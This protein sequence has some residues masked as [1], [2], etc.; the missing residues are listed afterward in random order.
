MVGAVGAKSFMNEEFRGTQKAGGFAWS[1][2]NGT[3]SVHVIEFLRM[4]Q[5]PHLPKL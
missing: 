5:A 2:R 4:V 3:K 1:G